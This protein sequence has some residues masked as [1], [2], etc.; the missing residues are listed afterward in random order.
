MTTLFIPDM[1]CGHCKASVEA[2][3]APLGDGLRIDLDRHV[4]ELDPRAA[5]EVLIAALARIGFPATVAS[6]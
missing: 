1:T 6:D 2:V 4:A 3:L 5:T